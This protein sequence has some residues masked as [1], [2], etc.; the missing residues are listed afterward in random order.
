[1]NIIRKNIV[2]LGLIIFCS[3]ENPLQYEVIE[4]DNKLYK[5]N[6][7]IEEFDDQTYINELLTKAKNSLSSKAESQELK[8]V[9]SAR[10]D[11]NDHLIINGILKGTNSDVDELVL[12]LGKKMS[13]MERKTIIPKGM[14]VNRVYVTFQFHKNGWSYTV[15]NFKYEQ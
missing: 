8:S 3:C 11:E 5:N 10:V 2:F 15:N 9:L 12:Y 7:P 4:F 6:I 14:R 1:M 13:K